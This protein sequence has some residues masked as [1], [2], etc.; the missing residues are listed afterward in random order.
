M[1]LLTRKTHLIEKVLWHYDRNCRQDSN[2]LKYDKIKITLQ[3]WSNR[4]N[5]FRH[6]KGRLHFLTLVHFPF[7]R[8][9]YK[10]FCKCFQN[11]VDKKPQTPIFI[12]PSLH[13]DFII[14]PFRFL[15][16]SASSAFLI[17]CLKHDWVESSYSHLE[18]LWMLSTHLFLKG[19]ASMNAMSCNT[20]M[21][22]ASEVGRVPVRVR[23]L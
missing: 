9:P 1:I 11:G 3:T 6:N 21:V 10:S 15:G 4:G 14:G 5:Y 17:H 12:L 22:F 18:F 2:R 13:L 7:F 19:T 20:S 16:H 23:W 8:A